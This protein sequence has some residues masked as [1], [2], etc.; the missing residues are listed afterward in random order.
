MVDAV[1]TGTLGLS[2]NGDAEDEWVS[3]MDG[4]RVVVL[5]TSPANRAGQVHGLAMLTG[6]RVPIPKGGNEEG[7]NS[8]RTRKDHG[9]VVTKRFSILGSHEARSR[10]AR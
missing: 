3:T 10:I 7:S 1:R 6:Y 2:G 9:S 5:R 8:V 4:R